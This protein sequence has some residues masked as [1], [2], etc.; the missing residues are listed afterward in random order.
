MPAVSPS[1]PKF[2]SKGQPAIWQLDH[3]GKQHALTDDPHLPPGFYHYFLSPSETKT[4][5]RIVDD[6]RAWTFPVSVP[7]HWSP[8]KNAEEVVE[9]RV[10]YTKCSSAS[11]SHGVKLDDGYCLITKYPNGAPLDCMETAHT[12]HNKPNCSHQ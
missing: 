4:N 7:P 12:W 11:L 10:R 6:F 9:L 8:S 2:A 5:Y 1:L 3:A